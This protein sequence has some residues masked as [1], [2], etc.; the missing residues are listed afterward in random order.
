M[1]VEKLKYIHFDNLQNRS[2]EFF[3]WGSLGECSNGHVS[4][5]KN[6]QF[7]KPS[8]VSSV[9]WYDNVHHLD[10]IGEH[11]LISSYSQPM[12]VFV[13]K[14]GILLHNV[15]LFIKPNQAGSNLLYPCP[16][17]VSDLDCFISQLGSILL[18]RPAKKAFVIPVG[19]QYNLN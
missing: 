4:E 2:S 3:N 13:W 7:K 17:I 16:P 18:E 11:K 15:R 5:T 10:H 6:A 14:P 9:V 8:F 12:V 1:C 19:L